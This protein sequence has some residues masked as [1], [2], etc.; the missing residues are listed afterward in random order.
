M[1]LPS[2]TVELLRRS[3]NE[4]ADRA[5]QP[6]TIEKIK[7]QA[8]EILQELPGTAARGI[9]AVMRSAEVGRK[10]VEK[11]ARKHTQIAVPMINATGTL[12]TDQGDG[13]A[14]ADPVFEIGREVMAGD[15]LRGDV[16]A[17]RLH[18]R[19]QKA[20]AD[21]SHPSGKPVSAA[22]SSSF[23][24]AVASVATFSDSR[25]I[26]V[27]RSDCVRLPDG[28]SLPESLS[29]I[30]VRVAGLRS[31]V[32]EVGSSNHRDAADFSS[33]ER[34]CVVVADGGSEPLQTFDLQDK[35]AI[36]VAVLPVGLIHNKVDPSFAILSAEALLADKI[37][38]VVLPGDGLVGGPASGI[39][40]GR[41]DLIDAI[42][43]SVA[44][45]VLRASDA[46]TAMTTV[47]IEID[48]SSVDVSPAIARL[49]TSEANL[50]D[51][52]ERL[53]TR[54]SGSDLIASCQVTADDARLTPKGRWVVPS[55][56][57]CIRHQSKSAAEW[58]QS[59]REDMPAIL[60]THD[61]TFVKV[62]LRWLNAAS[63]AKL[64]ELLAS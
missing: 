24:A 1:A 54:L 9:D 61:E 50:K 13:L 46:T 60:T 40:I 10:S 33:V 37:D 21:I 26:A 32:M 11:W 58:S 4:V 5:R 8:T 43:S 15:T 34:A 12:I 28:Q 20:V 6:E 64:G 23:A 42:T 2:W 3:L 53:A 48:G 52:A 62:D 59:L 18:R 47:A 25:T 51:R 31:T 57:L 56:Q 36:Q 38:V 29:S 35:E 63:D 39:L 7:T 19:L 22:I 45:R 27:H 17:E 30:G 49:Q 14:L 41:A 55:R 16:L 44:W